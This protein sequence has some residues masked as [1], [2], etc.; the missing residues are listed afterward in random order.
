MARTESAITH[1]HQ[2]SGFDC[3]VA[4]LLYADKCGRGH[5]G[6]QINAQTNQHAI[7]VFRHQLRAELLA[8][9][10]K[11]KDRDSEAGDTSGSEDSMST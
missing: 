10:D 8:D 4:C 11:D 6:E 1:A 2:V 5:S 9:R 3:G 7:T